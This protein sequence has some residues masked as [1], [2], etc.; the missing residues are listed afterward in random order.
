MSEYNVLSVT[1][2][3]KRELTASVESLFNLNGPWVGSSELAAAISH[4]SVGTPTDILTE[5]WDRINAL[6]GASSVL[7]QASGETFATATELTSLS[8]LAADAGDQVQA[9]WLAHRADSALRAAVETTL[10]ILRGEERLLTVS[11]ATNALTRLGYYLATS[12]GDRCTGL[13]AERD[14][15]VI[16]VLVQE[17]GSMQVDN[18]GLSGGGCAVPMREFQD[19]LRRE[20]LEAT[21]SSRAEHGDD[22]GGT[23]IR[24]AA[25]VS[26]DDLVSGLVLQQER[27]TS[28]R[29]RPVTVISTESAGQRQSGA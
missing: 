9:S 17:G 20:G 3:L 15:H 2:T 21:V 19:A 26:P 24:R 14:H 11:A 7:T 4:I 13:L 23:L 28:A 10:P 6:G 18:A 1:Y 16:A 22:R 5:R 12:A 29:R 27:P 25:A 8:R